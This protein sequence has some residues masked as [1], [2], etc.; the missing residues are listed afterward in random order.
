[1]QKINWLVLGVFFSLMALFVL[2]IAIWDIYL[3]NHDTSNATISWS[4]TLLSR[5]YP[6]LVFM[7]GVTCGGVLFGLAAHFWANQDAPADWTE[8]LKLR[9][10]NIA[11]R[12]KLKSNSNDTAI[13]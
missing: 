7:I 10:E 6:F 8:L 5:D 3:T 1:M 13:S 12:E 9:E 4:M 11:L 2:S